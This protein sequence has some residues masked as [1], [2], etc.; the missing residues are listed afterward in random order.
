[1]LGWALVT[2]VVF[3]AVHIPRAISATAV[4]GEYAKLK[5]T[6]GG[7][8]FL[9]FIWAIGAGGAM[10]PLLHARFLERSGILNDN[11]L[12]WVKALVIMCAGSLAAM[13]GLG[14]ALHIAVKMRLE[15][16]RALSKPVDIDG[17][18]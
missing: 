9:T 8:L 17:R 12:W 5:A 15:R 18:P 10:Y 7:I 11:P 16:H 1:M 4:D 3:A 6:Y 14:A 13:S 2:H